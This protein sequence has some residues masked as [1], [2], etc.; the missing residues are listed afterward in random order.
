MKES[1]AEYRELFPVTRNW[2]YF[3]HAATAPYS[4]LTAGAMYSYIKD[5][6]SN[7][8][9]NYENWE[10]LREETRVLAGKLIN[11][12][13]DEIALVSNTSEGA[14]IVAQGFYGNRGITSS[15]LIASSRP[16]IIP[17]R[18]YSEKVSRSARS[19]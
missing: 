10:K 18:I 3:N 13:P 11:C 6:E 2:I 15:S 5:M 7:G 14:N 16:T 17:G 1:F 19:R 4:S 12:G 9:K 8:G